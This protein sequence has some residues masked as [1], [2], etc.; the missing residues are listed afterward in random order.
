MRCDE[1]WSFVGSKCRKAWI[2][3]AIW[4]SNSPARSSLGNFLANASMAG[5]AFSG[6]WKSV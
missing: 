6:F 5:M 4:K 1:M 3:L 2:W